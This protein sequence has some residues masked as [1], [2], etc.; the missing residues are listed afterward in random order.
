[1]DYRAG[2]GSIRIGTLERCKCYAV[3]AVD[4][5]SPSYCPFID[6]LLNTAVTPYMP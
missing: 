6:H 3:L 2:V 1:M 5:L 4:A